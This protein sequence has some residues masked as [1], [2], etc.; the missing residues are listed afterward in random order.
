MPV[1]GPT[2]VL[3]LGDSNGLGALQTVPQSSGWNGVRKALRDRIALAEG[4][5]EFVGPWRDGTPDMPDCDH[6]AHGGYTVNQTREIAVWCI[7]AYS[8]DVVIIQSGSNDMFDWRNVPPATPA[9]AHQRMSLLL[10]E[11]YDADSTLETF[12]CTIPL[13]WA[14]PEDHNIYA[15]AASPWVQ[16]YNDNLALVVAERQGEGQH[17]SL[18]D[19][20]DCEA[21]GLH[22]K[23]A[24]YKK[25]GEKLADWM[26]TVPGLVVKKVPKAT[27]TA[28]TTGPLT[29]EWIESQRA[30]GYV[31]AVD[32]AEPDYA[33]YESYLRDDLF[34]YSGKARVQPTV[35]LPLGYYWCYV[36]GWN[37]IGWG[38]WSEARL[39][40]VA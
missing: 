7:N 1:S 38:T 18:V 8:P 19:T 9:N 25:A 22:Y 33:I 30:T 26:L 20:T 13:I 32:G 39:L 36:I 27:W 5:V 3:I 28:A 35:T 11:I 4:T 40:T 29:F 10:E 17:V 37:S 34:F 23:E 2:R 31:L 6:G 16:P 21:D 14:P 24:G 15:D 12:V